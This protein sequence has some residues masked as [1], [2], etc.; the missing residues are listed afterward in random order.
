MLPFPLPEAVFWAFYQ[1]IAIVMLVV[2]WI[3]LRVGPP[4]RPMPECPVCA[5]Q[6]RDS[7]N[8]ADALHA[9]PWQMLVP[10]IVAMC[11]A[12]P[13][14]FWLALQSRPPPHKCTTRRRD[15]PQG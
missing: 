9:L 2:T 15:A 13:Y 7:E 8:A 1:W 14:S 10:A 11:A 3:S 4:E 6:R 5:Q 12:W